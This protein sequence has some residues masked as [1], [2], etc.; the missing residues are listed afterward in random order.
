LLKNRY[1]SFSAAVK[2]TLRLAFK[3]VWRP[4]LSPPGAVSV[5]GLLKVVPPISLLDRVFFLFRVAYQRVRGPPFPLFP[6]L[7]FR[8]GDRGQDSLSVVRLPPFGGVCFLLPTI[9][10]VRTR[11]FGTPTFCVSLFI[12]LSWTDLDPDGTLERWPVFFFLRLL[13]SQPS[14]GTGLLPFLPA[15][16]LVGNTLP[17]RPFLWRFFLVLSASPPRCN[18]LLFSSLPPHPISFDG[19]RC[20]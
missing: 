18:S 2:K 7:F 6:G 20:F 13:H 19:H 9:V 10:A 4:G 11:F 17:G 16:Y 14:F 3:N 8:W 15:S 1:V 5:F 12:A